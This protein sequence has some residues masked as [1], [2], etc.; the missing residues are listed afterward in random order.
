MSRLFR[1]LGVPVGLCVFPSALVRGRNISETRFTSVDGFRNALG[2]NRRGGAGGGR[3][4]SCQ[5]PHRGNEIYRCD[6]GIQPPIP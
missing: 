2:L 1:T 5:I 3:L 4:R 6:R